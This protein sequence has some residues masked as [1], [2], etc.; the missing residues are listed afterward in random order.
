M[1]LPSNNDADVPMG[2]V[3][4]SSF[5]PTDSMPAPPPRRVGRSRRVVASR[6]KGFDDAFDTPGDSIP[7]SEPLTQQPESAHNN[8]AIEE[9]LFVSQSES[10]HINFES[11]AHQ[12]QSRTSRKRAASPTPEE[13][14]EDLMET[15]APT[16]A[17]LKR[18]RL[19]ETAARRRR[20]E[21]TP[22]HQRVIPAPKAASSHMKLKREK[23]EV[24][25]DILEVARQRREQAAELARAEREALE[26]A[27]DGVDINTIRK[28][29][30][31]EEMP[32][33]RSMPPPERRAYGDESER[34]E[35]KWNGRKNF[36]KFRRRGA[37]VVVARPS[38]V[39][40]P[41]EE[42]KKMD[43]G[44][45]DE[46]WLES[47]SGRKTQD[48][49]Q[50]QG[51]TNASS[52]V[53]QAT[54]PSQIS[55]SARAERRSP[56]AEDNSA[57]VVL[58][59]SD[60]EPDLTVKGEFDD[61]E[62]DSMPLRPTRASQTL[63][64]Q[65][66]SGGTK[67]SRSQKLTDKTNTE[68]NSTASSRASVASA[69]RPAAETLEKAGTGKKVKAAPEPRSQAA[70]AGATRAGSSRRLATP[71]EDPDADD[72]DDEEGLGFRF[73]RKR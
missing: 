32:V 38:K 64:S 44:I 66:S 22:P 42:V 15:V 4:D 24:E 35:D 1:V 31:I 51:G 50:R 70:R 63:T 68:Q 46:Y 29:A 5:P 30:I 60:N 18:R 8:L 34:W 6:F 67:A 33:V 58:L 48:R 40:V 26:E 3:P 13:S 36:K 72:D 27:M 73:R 21:S 16:A 7:E 12:A 59:S 14:E 56:S 61:D 23:K 37:E 45:G 2:D 65:P 54:A 9:T 55:R 41:L 49:S 11:Q 53:S 69:K 57:A 25:I 19:E 43:F 62:D 47:G 10:Q 39:I 17:Q 20:G 71:A 52:R 28:L